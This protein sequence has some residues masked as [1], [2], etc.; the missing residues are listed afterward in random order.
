M[1]E[2]CEGEKTIFEQKYISRAS[3]GWGGDTK[4]T[5]AQATPDRIGLFIDARGYLRMVDLDDCNCI[6]AGDKVS[7]DFCPFCGDNIKQSC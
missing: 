6:E 7:I 3:W 5:E 4:I 1:C 2:Y